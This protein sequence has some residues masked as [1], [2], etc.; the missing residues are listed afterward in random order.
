M[1]T[2]D[3]KIEE[4]K[5]VG[6]TYLRKLYRLNLKT[7]RDLFFHFPHRYDDFSKFVSIAQLKQGEI[8][9]IQGEIAETKNTN[10]F[11]R[12]MTLTETLIKDKTGTI[13]S[14][15]FN[16]PY[17]TETLKKGKTINLSGKL[18]FRKKVLCFSNPAYEV[19]NKPETTHTG[20]LV[21]IY[22]ETA[23]LT[24]RYLRYIIKPLL[25]LTEKTPDFLPLEIKKEFNLINLNQALKQIHFPDNL[26][27]AKR[28]RKRLAFNELFLIQLSN[29]KQKKRIGKRKISFNSF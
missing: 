8:A 14:I 1:L 22:H 18:V 7:V 24:S 6:P 11:P 23:G 21:P 9:T 10:I 3:S 28:A 5:K 15:W 20:R 16:Q 25:Y 27:S 2:L 4:I 13:K 17:L 12:R 19:I 29:L 26:L